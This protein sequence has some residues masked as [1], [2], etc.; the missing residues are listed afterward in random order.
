MK[1]GRNVV[2]AGLRRVRGKGKNLPIKAPMRGYGNELRADKNASSEADSLD[3][4]P[5]QGWGPDVLSEQSSIHSYD[6]SIG[7]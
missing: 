4:H 6:E 3:S 7:K 2:F 5:D 1:V